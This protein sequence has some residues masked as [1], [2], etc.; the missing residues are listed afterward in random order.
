VDFDRTKR[1]GHKGES[2]DDA[3]PDR[4]GERVIRF[5][6]KPPHSRAQVLVG[7]PAAPELLRLVAPGVTLGD[8]H[9]KALLELEGD[10][11]VVGRERRPGNS[12]PYINKHIP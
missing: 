11:R 7:E 8:A 4:W 5:L 9:P 12:R 3:R 6:D 10:E 1:F 2:V